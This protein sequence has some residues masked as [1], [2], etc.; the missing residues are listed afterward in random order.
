MRSLR[1]FLFATTILCTFGASAQTTPNTLNIADTTLH[2]SVK[3]HLGFISKNIAQGTVQYQYSDANGFTGSLSGSSIPWNGRQYSVIDTISSVFKTD[4]TTG[5]PSETIRYINGTY[6]KPLCHEDANGQVVLEQTG[7]FK[8]IHGEGTLS[9][10]ATTMEAVTITARMLSMF[11]YAYTLP[12]DTW[13]AGKTV[14]LNI[15]MPDDT[16]EFVEIKYVGERTHTNADGTTSPAYA[17]IFNYSYQGQLSKYPVEC[18]IDAT[19]HIPLFFA[20]D[21]S[22]GHMEMT[23]DS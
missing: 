8:N 3:F 11:Y 22:I 13:Q 16:Q 9:A 17:L 21:I 10:G 23:L 12:F 4:P 1:S 18:E 2:Y 6:T 20:A 7:A 5:L 15:V 14:K 19:R